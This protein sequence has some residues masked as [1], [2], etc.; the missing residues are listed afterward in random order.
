VLAWLGHSW[1]IHA[2]G[3]TSEAD[4]IAVSHHLLLSHGWAVDALRRAVPDADIGIS[5]N[6]AHVDAES[7]SP[8]DLAAAREVDGH[9][10]R[11]YLDPIFRGDYPA[12]MLERYA[13]SLP[14]VQDGDLKAMSARIDFLGVNTYFRH[15][16]RAGADGKPVMVRLQDAQFTDMGWEVYPEGMYQLLTRLSADYEPPVIY[17]T[18]SGAAFSDTRSHDGRVRDPERQA[19]LASHID[20]VGRAVE[21]GVPVQGYFV[22]SLLDNFEWAEGYSKRFGIVYVDYPTLERIPKESFDWYRELIA[23]A[24]PAGRPS[25]SGSRS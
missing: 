18:E 24:R 20:A 11:W 3:R 22:W 8:A 23:N 4:A 7:D 6:L 2:P 17:I 1:G 15:L 5:L 19:Y 13:A 12:D 25:L 10:N 14:P 9:S 16:V 21:A